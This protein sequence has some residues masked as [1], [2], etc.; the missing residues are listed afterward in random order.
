MAK[1]FENV[2]WKISNGKEI[3]TINRINQMQYMNNKTQ[4]LYSEKEFHENFESFIK[5]SQELRN[6]FAAIKKSSKEA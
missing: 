4:E 5:E 6:I 1:G 3:F 2:K